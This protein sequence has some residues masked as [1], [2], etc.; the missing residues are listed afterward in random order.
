M[1]LDPIPDEL[2]DFKK[3][4]KVLISKKI[5]FQKIVAMHGEGEVSKINGSICDIPIKAA[6]ICDNLSRPAGSIGLNCH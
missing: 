5:L 1:A 3:F 4:E 6:N 2:K